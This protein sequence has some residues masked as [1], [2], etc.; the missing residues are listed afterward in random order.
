MPVTMNGHGD[1][2]WGM[3]DMHELR[4]K[5]GLLQQVASAGWEVG[6]ATP[7]WARLHPLASLALLPAYGSMSA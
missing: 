7:Q 3:Y 6:G 4:E 1:I 5:R 2:R